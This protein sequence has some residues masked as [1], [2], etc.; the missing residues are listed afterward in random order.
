MVNPLS[1]APYLLPP[2]I[3]VVGSFIL[4]ALVVLRGRKSSSTRIFYWLLA[5]VGLTSFFIFGMRSSPDIPQAFLWQKPVLVVSWGIFLFYYHFT[6]V[7]TNARVKMGILLAIYALVISIAVLGGTTGLVLEGVRLEYY[8]Y[9]PT[10]TTLGLFL[11]T[12]GSILHVAGAYNL[13]KGYKRTASVAERNRLLYLAIAI[14]FP[15]LGG[16]LDGFTNLPPALIWG[17]LIFCIICTIAIVKYQLLDIRIVFQKSLVY[18]LVSGMIAVP[19]VVTLVLLNQL[20][21]AKIEPWWVHAL[22]I[23]LLAI[24]LRP[25]YSRAQN[26]VDRVFY[27]DR[28]DYLRALEQFSHQAQ[29]ILNLEE[30][31]SNM[32]KLISGAL[33]TSSACLLLTSEGSGGFVMVS[34]IGLENPLSGTVLRDQSLLVKWLRL[35]PDVLSSENLAIVPQLQSLSLIEKTNLEKMGAN[36]FV[37]IK[38]HEGELS[39]VLVLGQK[40]SQQTYSNED[41]QL[42]IALSSQMSV[43]LQN[44]RLYSDALRARENLETWLNSMSDCVMI[45]NTDYTIQFMNK[46]ARKKFGTRTGEKCWKALRKDTMCSSCPIQHYLRG[47]RDGL[48]YSENIGDR[49]YDVAAA[50]L[51]NPDGA[52]SIIEVLRD[53]TERKQAEE[54]EKQLQQQLYLSSRL[55]SI[56]ELAAGVA[57]E[58][59]NPLTGIL[60]FSQR[61]L[62]KSTDEGVKR[63]LGRIYNAALR[64][65]RV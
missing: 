44:A 39:G 29:S 52:L 48:H 58:I 23:L 22:I 11:L 33:R 63:D 5:S 4:L 65:A 17:N 47:D 38:R 6:V 3:T 37:P 42:L 35:H 51:L 36:L 7:Y 45:A 18:I 15:L 30:L 8:G 27:R 25:L 10:F 64:S 20:L 1:N 62:R 54:K 50:P 41:K 40:L 19:Y 21:E 24:L 55:A 28:Y 56:G 53:V 61:L 43:A 14:L 32:V 26:L 60:G 16:L 46:A 12:S 49:E 13:I 2:L 9:A 34:C 57:H 59:N 31:G